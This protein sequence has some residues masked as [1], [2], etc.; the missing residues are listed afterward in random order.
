MPCALLE[1]LQR[2]SDLEEGLLS[3]PPPEKPWSDVW[4]QSLG[5]RSSPLFPDSLLLFMEGMNGWMRE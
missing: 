1:N 3:A 5:K 4:L 2:T